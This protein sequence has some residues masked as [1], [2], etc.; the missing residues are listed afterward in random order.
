MKILFI[1]DDII[2]KPTGIDN[3]VDV[4][5]SLLRIINKELKKIPK[6][7]AVFHQYKVY[8]LEIEQERDCCHFLASPMTALP[9]RKDEDSDGERK[10]FKIKEEV[11]LELNETVVLNE[12]TD[13]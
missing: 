12:P 2:I 9:I 5:N 13:L 1:N 3:R 8:Q 6:K 10:N 4:L 11:N 7:T